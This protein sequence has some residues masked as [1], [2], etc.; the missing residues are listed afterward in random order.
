MGTFINS[1]ITKAGRILIARQFTGEKI[2]FTRIAMG[3]GFLPH[4]QAIPD[5]TNVIEHVVDVAITRLTVNADVTVVVGGIFSNAN[6]TAEF[7]YRELALFAHG[8]DGREVMYCYGNAGE[9]AEIIPP[10]GG[11]SVI[12]K[13][14]DIVTAIGTTTNVTANIIRATTADEISFDDR[15]V[16]L[17]AGSIQEAV[18]ILAR[19]SGVT[20]SETEPPEGFEI[21]LKPIGQTTFTPDITDLDPDAPDRPPQTVLF[22]LAHFFDKATRRYIPFMYMNTAGNILLNPGGTETVADAIAQ[23]NSGRAF[24]ASELFAHIGDMGVH[25]M[26]GQ[27]DNILAALAECVINV[28]DMQEQIA[29]ALQKAA[30]ALTVANEAAGAVAGFESRMNRIEDSVFTNITTNPF[31]IAFDSITDINIIKGIWN[32]ER[33]RIEC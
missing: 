7:P 10:L 27:L 22:F 24:T 25:L 15:S 18:E 8:E 5:M 21:W 12:E 6:I 23:L 33:Q 31:S 17:G 11:T 28:R 4:G 20:V 9:F 3:R 26:P 13:A 14:I 19:R 2:N 30:Q 1:D 29:A 32:R 16:N